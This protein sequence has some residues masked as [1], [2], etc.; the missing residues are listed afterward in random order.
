MIY[1]YKQKKIQQDCRYDC[2]KYHTAAKHRHHYVECVPGYP[3]ITTHG[4]AG[5]PYSP[6][7]LISSLVWSEI[8]AG[9]LVTV[10]GIGKT[11]GHNNKYVKQ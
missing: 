5:P 1:P 2:V 4:K 3:P 11:W 10:T 8:E 7:Q 9:A 6:R